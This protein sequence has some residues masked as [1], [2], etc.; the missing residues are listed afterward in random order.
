MNKWFFSLLFSLL[1]LSTH[2]ASLEFAFQLGEK[3]NPR[4]DKL[5]PNVASRITFSKDSTKLIAHEMGGSIVEWD[6]QKRQKRVICTVEED[7]WSAYTPRLN[8]L[9]TPKAD[10]G[11]SVID[12][13]NG[14]EI[15]LGKIGKRHEFVNTEN[16]INGQYKNGYFSQD[17]QLVA[18][19]EGGNE[20]ELWH[21]SNIIL[22]I[23]PMS[24]ETAITLRKISNFKTQLPVRNGI[25]ISDE[26]RYLAAAEGTYRDGEGHR[27]IIEVWMDFEKQPINVFNTREILGVWNMVFSEYG[28]IFATDTQLNG[29]SGIRVWEIG[30]GRQ[31]FNKSGFEAYWVRALAFAPNKQN[32]STDEMHENLSTKGYFRIYYLASGDEKG[33]LRVW[34]IPYHTSKILETKSV[35]WETYPTGIQTLAF[36]P[37]GEY[38]AVALWDTTIQILRWKRN[39]Q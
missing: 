10:K 6:L 39:E 22:H 5:L 32:L 13:A 2:G 36:S 12:V 18:L 23:I 4:L 31:L 29:K 35:I 34:G 27:T 26:N 9:L 21:F 15:K 38:L 8:S 7:Q 28:S 17:S 1:C 3:Q 19:T 14:N 20:I 37:N 25:A 33:N 24:F 16:E 11:I 30:S